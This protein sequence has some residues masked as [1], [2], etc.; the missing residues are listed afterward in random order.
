MSGEE[1]FSLEQSEE[2][3]A[4]LK[5]GAPTEFEQLRSA[6]NLLAHVPEM[7]PLSVPP[8]LP[9]QL[10]QPAPVIP[11]KTIKS[12]RT[13]ITSAIVTGLLASA[14]LAAAAVTGIGP[15]PIVSMGHQTAKFVRGVASAVTHVVT[16]GN[17]NTSD[18]N[19][20]TPLIPGLTPAP[21]AGDNSSSEGNSSDN[22]GA[23]ES[24]L[25]QVLAPITNLLNS[26]PPSDRK[27]PDGKS[28]DG[29]SNDGKGS[30]S[31]EGNSNSSHEDQSQTPNNLLQLLLTPSPSPIGER[32][33]PDVDEPAIPEPTLITETPTDQPTEMPTDLP[34]SN[35]SGQSDETVAVG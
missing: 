3:I 16:G 31:S 14:S 2:L 21:T 25:G 9:S 17:S 28:N 11:I 33:Q 18:E 12:P 15:A 6:L 19:S 7:P 13:I 30:N 32:V 29:K 23:D 10:N 20:A 35:S 22:S 24:G 26:P 5:S 34:S 8:V 1:D 4:K 27:T